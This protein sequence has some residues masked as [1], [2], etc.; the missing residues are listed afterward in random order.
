MALHQG[1]FV[2]TCPSCGGLRDWS[3]VFCRAPECSHHVVPIRRPK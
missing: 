2:P 3:W 1:K